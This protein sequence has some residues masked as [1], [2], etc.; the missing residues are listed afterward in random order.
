MHATLTHL[1]TSSMYTF[2]I[3]RERTNST[4][5]FIG[6]RSSCLRRTSFKVWSPFTLAAVSWYWQSNNFIA[7]R[8]TYSH[9]STAI[10]L[11]I[12]NQIISP[13]YI[14]SNQEY[15]NYKTK[16]HPTPKPKSLLQ[17]NTFL[18]LVLFN[19]THLSSYVGTFLQFLQLKYTCWKLIL[20]TMVYLN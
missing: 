9:E 13:R 19:V 7:N 5:S 17:T 18:P 16:V 10:G 20:L 4:F 1:W 14:W 11:L 8:K 6:G 2:Y 15:Q 12:T 3:H